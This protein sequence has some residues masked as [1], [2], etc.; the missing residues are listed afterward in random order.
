MPIRIRLLPVTLLVAG[1]VFTVRLGDLW[2]AAAQ[3]RTPTPVAAAV[4]A[5]PTQLAAAQAS[6]A[7]PV[8]PPPA[9]PLL[10]GD[11]VSL[12]QVEIELLQKLSARREAIERRERELDVR[13]ALIKAAEAR[14]TAKTSEL[15]TLQKRIE[16][17]MQIH[18]KQQAEKLDSLVSIYEKMKPRD[19]A[20]ILEGLE[21]DIL[22]DVLG[23]MREMRSAP[24]LAS[25]DPEK[26][27]A[28]TARLAER[29][30]PL[31]AGG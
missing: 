2:Q 20:R 4:A 11:G 18:D 29:N 12:S 17:L 1:A 25:M 30:V 27:R 19:A 14:M 13:E 9:M 26:A 10:P 23:R 15:A 8:A 21:M 6:A 24:I 7:E 22:I 3:L 5:E 31:R 28:V 16:D